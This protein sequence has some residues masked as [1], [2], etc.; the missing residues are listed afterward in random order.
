MNTWS[1]WSN[2][3]VCSSLYKRTYLILWLNSL[4]FMRQLRFI[5]PPNWS[6]SGK[7]LMYFVDRSL[8]IL[9]LPVLLTMLPKQVKRSTSLM[10]WP[11]AV[12][13]ASWLAFICILLVFVTLI[14]MPAV[15][16]IL[17]S[18]VLLAYICPTVCESK[19]TLSAKVQVLQPKVLYEGPLDALWLFHCCFQHPVDSQ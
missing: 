14:S 18:L 1:L 19:L 17:H 7:S 12:R 6:Q 5:T 4:S 16:A 2:F 13:G 8:S 11:S 3:L 15:L 10:A 9:I